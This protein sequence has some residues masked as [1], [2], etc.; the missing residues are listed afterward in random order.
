[1]AIQLLRGHVKEVTSPDKHGGVDC[2]LGSYNIKMNGDLVSSI[3]QGDD[4]LLACEQCNDGYHG[5][6]VKNIDQGKTA[7]IDPTNKILLLA[8]SVF[9]CTLGFVLDF[10]AVSSGIMV[11]SIDTIIGSI[12]LIGIVITVRRL[13][14][15]SRA[16]TWVRHVKI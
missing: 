15:I 11:R 8:G 9:L 14:I 3:G 12:G 13:F 1:M 2:R 4:I 10:Q 6:A 7:Q 5:L 16:G